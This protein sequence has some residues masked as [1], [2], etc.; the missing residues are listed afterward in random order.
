VTLLGSEGAGSQ[1][2]GRQLVVAALSVEGLVLVVAIAARLLVSQLGSNYDWESEKIVAGIV[3]DGGNVYAETARYNYG[4]VFMAVLGALHFLSGSDQLDRVLVVGFLTFVDLGIWAVLRSQFGRV[5]AAVFLLNPISIIITGYHNQFDNLALLFGLLAVV[6]LRDSA[7]GRPSNRR[8]LAGLGLLGLSLCTKHVF[9]VF[10]LWIA[11]R[12]LA[13]GRRLAALVVPPL[14]FVLSFTP[15]L[16]HGG[17]DGIIRN[18]V[19]YSSADNSPLMHLLLPDEWVSA[20][21]ATTVFLGVLV[22]A[23][24]VFRT[25]SDLDRLLLYTVVLVVFAPAMANQY[26]AIP[27]AAAVVWLNIGFV[28]YATLS[29]LFLGAHP[30]GFGCLAVR[31][32]LPSQMV[33]DGSLREW[34]WLTAALALSLLLMVLS[35]LADERGRSM[36]RWAALSSWPEG[37]RGTSRASPHVEG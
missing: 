33:S 2:R 27:M 23:A 5:A 30:N 29:T 34:D 17:K 14:L 15:F 32:L 8:F 22:A 3:G 24:F 19:L 25:R 6:V 21:L 37:S 9:F 31:D 26:L 12:Q 16:P 35:W 1:S 10:P 36:P 7:G 4:P 13:W 28:L 18:V 11:V 20:G